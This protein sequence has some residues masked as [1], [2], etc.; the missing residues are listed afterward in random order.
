MW[1]QQV[2]GHRQHPLNLPEVHMQISRLLPV[3]ALTAVAATGCQDAQARR[4]V[5]L[6]KHQADSV[7]AEF[8]LYKDWLGVSL[9]K[10]EKPTKTVHT[11][12]EQVFKAICNLEHSV[13]PP[14]PVED[15]LCHEEGDHGGAPHPPPWL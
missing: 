10:H 14:V 9:E 2:V 5:A 15:R 12:H 7:A 4:D 11:W 3:V 13:R 1:L 6:L 8:Q